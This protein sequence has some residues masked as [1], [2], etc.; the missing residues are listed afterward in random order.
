MNDV[1]TL[2]PN[3]TILFQGDSITDAGRGSDPSGM[4]S[5]YASMV[6]S[7][8]SALYPDRCRFPRHRSDAISRCWN[9]HF[10]PTGFCLG[11]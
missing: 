6:A 1:L 10:S 4:G 9:Q 8:G 7:L 5:G 11:T 3:S 2:Q